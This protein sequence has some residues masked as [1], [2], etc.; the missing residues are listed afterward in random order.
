MPVDHAIDSD[1]DREHCDGG[2]KTQQHA[3]RVR[4]VNGHAQ[5]FHLN[6]P[7]KQ[8]TARS[9]DGLVAALYP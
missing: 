1:Q 4:L 2:P 3:S 5:N 6:I 7:E 8:I 9:F